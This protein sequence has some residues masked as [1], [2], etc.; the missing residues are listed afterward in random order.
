VV[1]YRLLTVGS[2]EI[3]MMKKQLS[4]KK[5]ER[6]T[7]HGG[8]FRKAGHRG[9]GVERKS[10][11]LEDLRRLLE[12]DV[13]VDRKEREK[14]KK[15]LQ[16]TDKENTENSQEEENDANNEDTKAK[17]TKDISDGELEVILDRFHMFSG[18]QSS[19]SNHKEPRGSL[20]L[21]S[22]SKS[23]KKKSPNKNKKNKK[24]TNE[25]EEKKAQP[26]PLEGDMYD[27]VNMGIDD[28]LQNLD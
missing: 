1:V 24:E 22:P 23:D 15:Q 20:S 6:L 12:D 25:E 2:V 11:S 16:H 3:D 17:L 8:D 14:D 10:I 7:I 13:K 5:L 27:F 18:A 9:T 21:S 19:H 28:V 4:K 26:F